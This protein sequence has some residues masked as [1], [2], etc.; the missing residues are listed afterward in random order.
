MR[1]DFYKRK[2]KGEPIIDAKVNIFNLCSKC[3]GDLDKPSDLW[4]KDCRQFV[5]KEVVK[6]EISRPL[7]SY[8]EYYYKFSK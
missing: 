1:T 5:D 3:W 7:K 2:D 4:C 8:F 6:R